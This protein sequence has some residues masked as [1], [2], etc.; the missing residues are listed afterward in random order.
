MWLLAEYE[1]C[2]LFSLRLGEAT[3]TGAKTLL[4]PSP[5]AI[6]TALLDVA[7][8]LRGVRA[9]PGAFD[10]LRRFKLAT[11]PPDRIAVTNLFTKVRKPRRGGDHEGE[12]EGGEIHEAMQPT[13]GF[14]EYAHLQG[15]LGLAFEG[16]EDDL[17]WL[18]PLL[19]HVTYLGKRGSFFQL[20]D[21]PQKLETLPPGFLEVGD[22]VMWGTVISGFPAG[23]FPLG[24]L[25][26]MDD[27]GPD[28]TWDKVNVYS[29]AKIVLGADR[30]R[31]GAILPYRLVASSRGFSYYERLPLQFT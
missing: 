6:R 14:R 15:T 25:Q 2:T 1:A 24:I 3:A 19:P 28:L 16:K 9:G 26:L 20:V 5:F 8:R 13:I 10:R 21:L 23:S 29:R 17:A 12:E 18:E 4:L 30:V 31:K 7:V 11:Q 27:W 22:E